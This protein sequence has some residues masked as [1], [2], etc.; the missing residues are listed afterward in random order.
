MV[1]ALEKTR[2]ITINTFLMKKI[3]TILFVGIIL[4]TGLQASAQDSTSFRNGM[5]RSKIYLMLTAGTQGFGGDIKVAPTPAFNVRAGVSILPLKLNRPYPFNGQPTDVDFDGDFANGHLMFDWHPF[6]NGY[7]VSR[8]VIVTAGAGYFWKNNATAVISYRGNKQYG[9]IVVPSSDL[10]SLIGEVKWNKVAPYLGFGF[11]N[12]FPNNRM[13]LGFAV[14]MYY[15][16]K[17]DASLTGTKLLADNA[18][19]SEQFQKNMNFYRFLPVV[20]INF[21]FGL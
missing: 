7:K 5:R 21:N 6:L 20:Q 3:F 10:G 4:L 19:N 15:M 1:P 12:A 17:P 14:G 16:G 18:N 8:K 11:E 2:K 13:S 9:D